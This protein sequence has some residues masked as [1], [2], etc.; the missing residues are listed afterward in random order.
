MAGET[1]TG[2]ILLICS[3]MDWFIWGLS[4]FVFTLG[5]RFIC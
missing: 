4:F 1:K 5:L 2:V 3:F